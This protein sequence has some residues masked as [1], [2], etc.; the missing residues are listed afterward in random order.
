VALVNGFASLATLIDELITGQRYSTQ[1]MLR[2][3]N[4]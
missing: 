2:D 1:A 4:G 3:S